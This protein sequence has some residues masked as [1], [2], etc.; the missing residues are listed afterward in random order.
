MVFEYGCG[1]GTHWWAERSRHV[2]VVEHNPDW[3]RQISDGISE[4]VNL[5]HRVP[6]VDYAEAVSESGYPYDVIVVDGK[7]REDCCRHSIHHLTESGIIVLDDTDREVRKGAIKY[8]KNQGF[9]Q[10]SLVG[11]SPIEFMECETSIFYRDGNLLG[12]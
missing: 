2:D 5:M 4:R 10:L 3:I 1:M 12:L 9:R 8:L 11:F 6:G 7:V